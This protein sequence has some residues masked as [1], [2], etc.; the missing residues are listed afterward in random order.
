MKT[1]LWKISKK[2]LSKTNLTQYSNF[3]KKNYKTNL[4]RNFSKLWKWSIDNPTD[5]WKSIWKFTRGW[6]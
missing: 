5:F 2:K 6:I 1:Y 4:D 3:V